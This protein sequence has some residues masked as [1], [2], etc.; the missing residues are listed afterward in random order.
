[1]SYFPRFFWNRM[2]IGSVLLVANSTQSTAAEPVVT[3]V[4]EGLTQLLG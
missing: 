1:M 3:Q 2:L 4:S